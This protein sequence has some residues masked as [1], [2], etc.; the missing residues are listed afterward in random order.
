MG[1]GADC[2]EGFADRPP[3]S[4]ILALGVGEAASN[5]R[6]IT[7]QMSALDAPLRN[8]VCACFFSAL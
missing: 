1:C 2:G 7:F 6:W 5:A 3:Y 8:K 4:S